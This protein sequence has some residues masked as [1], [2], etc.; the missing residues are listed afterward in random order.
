[1]LVTFAIALVS[2]A[3]VAF[4]RGFWLALCKECINLEQTLG[5][6]LGWIFSTNAAN[7]G[8]EGCTV[9]K[10]AAHKNQFGRI[11]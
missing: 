3:A 2:I 9:P 8:H 5:S 1:M 6:L 4:Y 11:A 10:V 7:N